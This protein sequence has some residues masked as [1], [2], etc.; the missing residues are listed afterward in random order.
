MFCVLGA[1]CVD[2]RRRYIDQ[3]DIVFDTADRKDLEVYTSAVAIA[4]GDGGLEYDGTD[5]TK[6]RD[7]YA[8]V[9]HGKAEYY[10]G[11]GRREPLP[12]T[13]NYERWINAPTLS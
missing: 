8:Y 12:V 10:E 7:F 9:E 3:Y 11:Y 13:F 5:E 2:E 4:Y 6:E 1:F